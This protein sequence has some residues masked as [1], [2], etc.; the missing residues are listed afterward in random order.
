M[1]SPAQ[2]KR[3]AVYREQPLEQPSVRQQRSSDD[4]AGEG[5]AGAWQAQG[6]R[7]LLDPDVAQALG[8]NERT[9]LMRF[10]RLIDPLERDSVLAALRSTLVRGGRLN[11]R[12]K[13]VG[14]PAAGQWA[15]LSVVSREGMLC[16]ALT[17]LPGESTRLDLWRD[18]EQRFRA[19]FDQTPNT[20][21]QG[22]DDQR[23][24]IYWNE[25]SERLY[26]WRREEAL[27]RQLEELI[28]PPPMRGEVVRLHGRWVEHGEEIPAAELELQRRDGSL[29]PVFSSHVMLRN[30][31]GEPEMYCID[32]D[33]RGQRQ[34]VQEGQRREQQLRLVSQAS[35]V[36]WWEWEPG[37]DR[38]R[39]SPELSEWF[40]GGDRREA[41]LADVMAALPVESANDIALLRQQVL[42]QP[43][44][45]TDLELAL[46]TAQGQRVFRLQVQAQALQVSE[47]HG[48]PSRRVGTLLDI[49]ES[50]E[51]AARID[52][53]A[54]HDPVTGLPNR[55]LM[56]E[57]L[58]ESVA[59]V[60]E[61]GGLV[62]V[63]CLGLDQ[64][65]LINESYG[66]A[67]GDAVLNACAERLRDRLRAGDLVVRLSGDRFGLLLEGVRD[68]AEGEALADKLLG[69][70]RQPFR[71]GELELTLGASLGLSLFPQDGDDIDS[72]LQH[73][74]TALHR[75]KE[76]GRGFH[77]FYSAK[78]SRDAEERVRLLGALRRALPDGELSL[79]FQP[80]RSLG[81]GALV[82]AEAL[83]RWQSATL[84]AVSPAQFIPLAED[85]GLIEPIG[86][87]V[88]EQC[89]AA[90]RRW[91]EAGH[92]GLHLAMNV[93]VRQFRRG[94]FADR[95][96]DALAAHGVPASAL[97]LE[98]TESLLLDD[99][100][101]TLQQFLAL[102]QLG[103]SL[104]ID[105]FGTGYSSLSYLRRFPIDVLKI[106]RSFVQ[107]LGAGSQ[108]AEPLVRAI[109]G[110]AQALR[111]KVVAEGVETDAQHAQLRQLGCD[112]GQGWHF[113]RPMLAEAFESLL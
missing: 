70:F 43:E 30:G 113:G 35:R 76:L 101:Q 5:F 6:A 84:G 79:H 3:Q 34:A 4:W 58:A 40:G 52:Q 54:R 46:A 68:L 10:V 31:W 42:A 32:V 80:K 39:W 97:E 29:V 11:R 59:R 62:L 67:L 18:A 66:T 85:S 99:H 102:R 86:D 94:H 61:R 21:V 2:A 51:A 47:D 74:E 111:L 48:L 72:L 100:G 93:S 17:D 73:A 82:G 24:V 9:S 44:R 89:C 103:V 98:V 16:G 36:G 53:L 15:R 45:T 26:G 20:A 14:G 49:T 23:R 65:R 88:L 90:L 7:L 107:D 78:M 112:L 55:L 8:L 71:V 63:G 38:L 104:A 33:L 50:R 27:G 28:I 87:W 106:D 95:V 57:R 75:V 22:Y 92:T 83:L 60:S 1:L 19:A 105:D 13:L 37:S 108:D 64:F 77:T 110:M 91:R 41:K 25:A 81:D 69:L 12:F 109:I 56:S 96:A